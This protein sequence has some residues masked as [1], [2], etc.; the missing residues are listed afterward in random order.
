[1]KNHWQLYLH[2]P[3]SFTYISLTASLTSPWQLHLHLPD[4]STYISLTAPLTSPWQLHLHLHD[5]VTYISLTAPLTSPW[6]L[7]LHLPDSST[8]ISLIAPLTSPWQRSPVMNTLL[9]FSLRLWALTLWKSSLLLLAP[10]CQSSLLTPAG[11]LHAQLWLI[12]VIL[13]TSDIYLTNFTSFCLTQL[14]RSFIPMFRT[15]RYL[16]SHF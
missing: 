9:Q 7:H 13:C 4:S 1:M 11:R 3:D 12:S 8:Y 14:H 2:L 16:N 5:S 10:L 6:Q 15:P